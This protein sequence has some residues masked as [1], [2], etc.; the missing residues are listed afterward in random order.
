MMKM[1]G[2]QVQH[3]QDRENVNMTEISE[4]KQQ[5]EK[6]LLSDDFIELAAMRDDFN[7]F[8][9]LNLQNNEVKH[10]R[11]LGWLL[12]P[13]ENHYL[14]DYFLIEFLK[15]ALEEPAKY[16]LTKTTI[17]DIIFAN[18]I[19]ADVILEKLTDK[20]R[21]MDIFIDSPSNKLVCIIENK[22]WSGEGCN[23]L[24]DYETYINSHEIYK[25]YKHKIFIFLTPNK[26]Y[27]CTKLYK[28]YIRLDYGKVAQAIENL[29]KHHG[30]ILDNGVRAFIEDYKKMIERNI[31][32][33]KDKAI[34]D[35]CRK[36]YRNNKNA[37]DLIVES[38]GCAQKD[39]DKILTQVIEEDFTL[40]LE[41][42][43]KGWIRFTPKSV[44]F[45]KLSFAKDDWVKSDKIIM[46][47]I[48]NSER[49]KVSADIIVR[50]SDDEKSYSKV[51]DVAK[52]VF[53]YDTATKGY[54]HVFSTS[55]IGSGEYYALLSCENIKEILKNRLIESGI[56]EKFNN[57]AKK[58]SEKL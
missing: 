20:G 45:S 28:N 19:D 24:E 46:I 3:Q 8:N 52:E 13:T 22:I 57:F 10:S 14:G 15:I 34:V 31:M 11:F 6:L 39:I 43:E 29:L 12:T 40:T 55:L 9:V 2:Q 58:I 42:C 26:D 53:N 23:Q 56:I 50:C 48:N 33:E 37:I 4:Q 21:R 1:V 35:L 32:G 25:N 30:S 54:A 18:L 41:P 7:I 44:N 38:V 51:L 5:L 16:N 17:S 27:D 47:E 49:E 36:I